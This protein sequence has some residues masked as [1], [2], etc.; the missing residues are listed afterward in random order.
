MFEEHKV[1][2]LWVWPGKNFTSEANSS[3]FCTKP[4]VSLF[5]QKNCW[6]SLRKGTSMAAQLLKVEVVLL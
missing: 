1:Y 2:L 5:F 6:L 4:S 3:L